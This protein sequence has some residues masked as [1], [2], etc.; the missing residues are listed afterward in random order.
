MNNKKEIKLTKK[1]LSEIL[2][3]LYFFVI[4]KNN[5]S[6][7]IRILL[8]LFFLILATLVNVFVPFLYGKS[9]DLIN[10]NEPEIFSLLILIIGSY[11]LAKFGK[12]LFDEA[13]DFIFVRVTQKAVRGAALF[14][15]EHLHNLSLAFHL[16]RQTG[17]LARSV[18]RGAKGV[19]LLLRY[20]TFEIFP[21]FAELIIVSVVLWKS[22]GFYYS[23]VTF[24]TVCLYAYFTLKV[25]EWR[26]AIRKKMNEADDNAATRMIDSLLNYETVK[27]FNTEKYEVAKYNSSLRNYE[28]KAVKTRIS[29]TFVNLGQGAIISSGLFAIM[30]MAAYDISIDKM[31]I[32]DFVIVNTFLLQLYVPLEYLGFIYREI[33][34]SIFDMNRMFGLMKEKDEFFYQQRLNTYNIKEGNIKFVNVSFSF[35]NR[36]VLNNISFNIKKNESVAI[37]G[38][39]GCGK[40]TLSK[41]LFKFYNPNEGKIFID[42]L[43]ISEINS[44]SI[45]KKI[46]VVPQ[47]TMMFNDTLRYNIT[48]GN[49]NVSNKKIRE[50]CTLSYI[51]N[52]ISKLELKLETVIGE[53]G[54]KLSG[55]EKQRIAIARVMLKKI[56]IL[57]LDESTSAL[58]LRTERNVLKSIKHIFKDTTKII[59]AH[60]LSTIK[61]VDQIIVLDHGKV[62]ENGRHDDLILSNG[63]YKEMW[64]KQKVKK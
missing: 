13:K 51:E 27:Y 46:G 9:V 53:R 59:I 44:D 40:S 26:I 62:V 33:R 47:D 2:K 49:P 12:I 8:S 31:S 60:R 19:E 18:D 28:D 24:V 58:D 14:A 10:K 41:L 11:A 45:R 4:P 30:S 20:L 16:N 55:G 21:I 34:Q 25:T 32:G 5:K 22:F 23:A 39:T 17:G 54:L 56:K 57:I 48:Y 29:L 42:G 37:V 43:D 6:I 61:D 52:F 7:P 63:L 64:E 1:E 38:P 36:K 3:K 15:F 35:G 50:I